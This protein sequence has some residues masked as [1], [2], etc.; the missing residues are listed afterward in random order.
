MPFSTSRTNTRPSSNIPLRNLA[1]SSGSASRHHQDESESTSFLG[2]HHS[3]HH[4]D[5]PG[6][7]S[8][9]TESWVSTGDIGE[10]IDAEDPLRAR[11]NDTLDESAL[12]GLKHLP[13]NHAHSSNSASTRREKKHVRIHED[14]DHHR[15]S[16]RHSSGQAGVVNKEAIEIPEPISRR[17][18]RVARLISSIMPGSK[19][20]TGKPLM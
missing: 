16:H 2:A 3:G 4:V 11:L 5:K 19:G 15:R 20:F 6:S 13:R 12:A 8:D 18:S 17:P 9:D 1:E 14:P 10:Q 7:D